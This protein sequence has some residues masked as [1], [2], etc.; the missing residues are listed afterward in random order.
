MSL[1][2]E[3]V[4]PDIGPSA[5]ASFPG[6]RRIFLGGGILLGLAISLQRL[7]G[8]IST[9]LAARIGGVSTLGRYSVALSTVATVTAFMGAGVGTVAL[10]YAGQYPRNTRA[11][12]KVLRLL[13][14]IGLVATLASTVVL[15]TGSGFLATFVLRNSGLQRLLQVAALTSVAIV[16]VEALNGTFI[17][18]HNFR[19][20]LWLSTVSGVLM[21][22]AVSYGALYGA[23]AMVLGYT[24]AI[25]LGVAVTLIAT[26]STVRPEPPDGSPEPTPPRS[27]EVILF[28]NAQQ[29]NTIVLALAS[30]WVIVTVTR[31][32][33]SFRQMGYYVVGSQLRVLATQ[34]PALAAQLVLPTL[35]RTASLPQ[36]D[37]V[38][39]A[40]TFLCVALCFVSAGLVLT[41]LPW[42]L[43]AYGTAFQQAS[44]ACSLLLATAVAQL[45]Y[46]PAANALLMLS[47]RISV[48][49]NVAANLA[50]AFLATTLS[51]KIGAAGAAA[52]WLISQLLLQ[53]IVF[54]ALKGMK[55]LPA[56]LLLISCL[57]NLGAIGLTALAVIRTTYP[58]TSIVTT[59]TQII[60]LLVAM[61]GFFRIAQS[62][63]Y[64][65]RNT[66]SAL[67][68]LRSAPALF[69]NY[70]GST[71]TT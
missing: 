52:A 59:V 58:A 20:L 60:L 29:L 51:G 68:E 47:L 19:G 32:D 3:P 50:L 21:V 34:A 42:I 54:G 64:L 9:A 30:W 65:P 57:G 44:I 45:T 10:R 61:F 70:L 18:L 69:I 26:R 37:R 31:F 63:G 25:A 5:N 56:G 13:I 15:F 8:F 40:A 22:M 35:S 49:T 48:L 39:S 66:K 14:V 28:G 2:S 23:S 38:V 41:F 4:P 67:A 71:R 24:A 12:R 1:V 46:I 27:R 53:V 36:Q 33:P 11:Y 55:R 43:S 16:T 7:F 62:R 6:L 17:A